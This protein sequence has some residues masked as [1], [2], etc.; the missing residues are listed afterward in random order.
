MR[1]PVFP[2]F[3]MA[4]LAAAL[5]P[6]CRRDTL[7]GT[8]AVPA[9]SPSDAA[10]PARPKGRT[11][12]TLF[13]TSQ[14]HGRLT[15]CGCF[16]GQFGG[17]SRLRTAL[18]D[19]GWLAGARP[20]G[21]DAGDA[22]EGPEDYHLLKYKQVVAAYSEMGY[23]ALNAGSTEAA[24]PAST[25]QWLARQ[26]PVPL[27]SANLLDAATRRPA[28]PPFTVIR[29]NGYRIGIAGVVDP[30][31]VRDTLG[32]GLE[33]E[34]V[35]TA[36]ARIL[37]DLKKDA[38]VLILLA[39]TDE[40]TLAALARRFYEFRVI[41]GGK[42][43]Q[44]AQELVEENRS[45]V[46]YTGNES[47]SFGALELVAAAGSADLLPGR[48]EMAL[49]HD[50]YEQHPS[51]LLLDAAYRREVRAAHLRLDSHAHNEESQIPG[52]RAAATYTGSAACIT[53]HPSAGEAWKRS[54]HAHA[55]ETLVRRDA[56][57][58]PSCIGCH[59][60]GFGT[61]S[62][63]NRLLR[64]PEFTAVGCESCHGPGSRHVAQRQFGGPATFRF[65]PLATGDCMKCHHGEFS[66]PFDWDTFWP[67]VRHGKEPQT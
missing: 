26:S 42:V 15:P 54:L 10:A 45:L 64:Q 18:G 31:L 57:A 21:L 2:V 58:D 7:T 37:P 25:L 20:F 33:A 43:S 17:I 28:L 48:H 38:D 61:P 30:R 62:G 11:A 4:L 32:E 53:C 12:F 22:L 35:D 49:L 36:L 44:P 60:V 46:Y 47:K 65:R 52:V 3:L 23:A 66:R 63:Y 39:F 14:N 40:V 5:L 34:P 9:A 13:F 6:A 8:R 19:T 24:L 41:L 56:D 27:V 55:F 51:I 59:T 1:P 16:T 29:R 67:L 50:R